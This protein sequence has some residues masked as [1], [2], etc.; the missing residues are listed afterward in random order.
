MDP[1]WEATPDLRLSQGDVITYVPVVVASHR[2]V[3]LTAEK[4]GDLW[5]GSNQWAPPERDSGVANALARGRLGAVVVLSH[6]CELD[7]NEKN[8]RVVVAPV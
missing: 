3:Q 7:K 1:W 2:L 8:A 4:G 5:R 6:D